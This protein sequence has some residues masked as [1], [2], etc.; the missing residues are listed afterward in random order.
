[1]SRQRYPTDVKDSEWAVLA[2][3]MPDRA[4]TGRPRRHNHREIINAI[5]Y[6]LSNGI[7]W[8]AMPHDLPPWST[9]Y[10]YFRRWRLLG[11]WQRWNAA[12]R[13][14]LTRRLGR[15][16]EASAAILDSQ[17]IKTAEGGDNRGY[18]ANKRCSGR[19]RHILV[20][21]LGLLLVVMVTAASVQDRDGA[22]QLLHLFY[23]DFFAS[24][25]LKRIWLVPPRVADGGYRGSLILK[26][27]TSFDWLLDIVKR[28][29]Q[30]SGFEVLPK[31]WIVERTFSWFIRNRRLCRDYERLPQT[32]ETFIYITMIRLMSRRLAEF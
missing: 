25:R 10:G 5:F 8:R 7:K 24:F 13:K 28:N 1:M 6:V 27:Q 11:Y 26:V 30:H 21:T 9:V 23:Q 32:S 18:D 16:A 14:R 19:K 29:S 15:K 2:E 20:D 17:S 12:L 4:S 22:K 31:R 3:L